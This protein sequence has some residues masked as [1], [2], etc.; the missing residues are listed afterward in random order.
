[1]VPAKGI[2]DIGSVGFA[3]KTAR[4]EFKN[5][6][7]LPEDHFWSHKGGVL[8]KRGVVRGFTYRD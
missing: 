8:D 6:V 1:M 7:L 3:M 2:L 5:K 4:G